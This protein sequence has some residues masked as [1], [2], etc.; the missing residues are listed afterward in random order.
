M[1]SRFPPLETSEKLSEQGDESHHEEVGVAR[2]DG[3]EERNDLLLLPSIEQG[4][5]RLRARPKQQLRK[6]TPRG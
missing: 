5:P 1:S 4:G 6:N 3:Q 2:D